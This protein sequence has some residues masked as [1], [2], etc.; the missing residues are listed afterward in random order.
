[1][2]QPFVRRFDAAFGLNYPQ[3]EC[4]ASAICQELLLGRIESFEPKSVT[5]GSRTSGASLRS[6]PVP[7]RPAR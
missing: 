5:S 3:R 1:L 6:A 2:R 7:A 4:A